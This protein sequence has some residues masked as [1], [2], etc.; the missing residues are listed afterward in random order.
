V[1]AG[2]NLVYTLTAS[3][4]GPLADSA[5]LFDTLPAGTSFV[6]LVQGSGAPFTCTTPAVGAA[7]SISCTNATF[8]SGASATFT[9]TVAVDASTANGTTIVN[10]ASIDGTRADPAAANDAASASTTASNQPN[11]VLIKTAPPRVD[12]GAPI[13]YAL[14]LANVGDAPALD[15]VLSDPLPVPTGFVSLA[16]NEGPAFAC[17]T[18]AVGANGTVTCSIASLAAG[19][20]ARFTLTVSAPASFGGPVSNTANAATASADA[21]P[22]DNAS[23]AATLI[24]FAGSGLPITIPTL[25]WFGLLALAAAIGLLGAAITLRAR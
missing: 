18:P 10:T 21:A 1:A 5:T 23:T 2:G 24:G 16:Q 8:A 15:V 11:L 6:S 3:N 13:V 20:T 17:T 7:G 4:A 12:P 22:A 14:E 25:S 9:L 19:A